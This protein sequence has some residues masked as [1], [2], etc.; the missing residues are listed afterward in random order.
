VNEL[1]LKFAMET[2]NKRLF[3]E[4]VYTVSKTYS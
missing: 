4:F 1:F 2:H 3:M